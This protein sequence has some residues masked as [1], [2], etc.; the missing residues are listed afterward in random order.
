MKVIKL[1][2]FTVNILE[3]EFLCH[4]RFP[5]RQ[6]LSES[7]PAF[8]KQNILMIVVRLIFILLRLS[9]YLAS[10]LSKVY[11]LIYCRGFEW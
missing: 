6:K 3:I 1:E 5:I 4:V 10:V 7:M 9:Y 11:T 8:E 2:I